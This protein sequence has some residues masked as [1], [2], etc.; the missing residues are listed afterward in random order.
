M[1]SERSTGR[2]VS[3]WL[4]AIDSSAH[5]AFCGFYHK[6]NGFGFGS[7]SALHPRFFAVK[8]MGQGSFD[9]TKTTDNI[10]YVFFIDES[11]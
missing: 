11:R 10:Y 4:L 6:Q 2:R 7:Q 3:A 5:F 1:I 8:E 9:K